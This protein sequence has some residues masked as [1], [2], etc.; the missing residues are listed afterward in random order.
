MSLR[1]LYNTYRHG[2]HVTGRK[3]RPTLHKIQRRATKLIIP[4]LRDL[5]SMKKDY[6]NVV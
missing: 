1:I 5:I 6:S 2:G 4:G 3:Y